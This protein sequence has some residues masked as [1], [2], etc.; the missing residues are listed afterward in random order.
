MAF[1]KKQP[2]ILKDMFNDPYAEETLCMFTPLSPKLRYLFS[3]CTISEDEVIEITTIQDLIS[4][5]TVPQNMFVR[6]GDKKIRVR[7]NG[8][9]FFS[10]TF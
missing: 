6:I 10:F 4:I 1:C 2:T 7:I 8:K 5:V 3:D 9:Y